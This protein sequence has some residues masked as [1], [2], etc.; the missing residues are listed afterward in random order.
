MALI[1]CP[2]CGH[3]VLSVA[4]TCPNCQHRMT[5]EVAHSGELTTV[6]QCR[7]CGELMS[8]DSTR[9]PHCG[10]STRR[11]ILVWIALAV[12]VVALIAVVWLVLRDGADSEPEAP[13]PTLTPEV[14]R[15]P[16]QS[17]TRPTPRDIVEPAPTEIATPLPRRA[18]RWA[19]DW[20]NV[21]TD[22]GL[23]Y[24][25]VQILRPGDSVEVSDRRLGWWAVHGDGRLIGYVANNLLDTVPPLPF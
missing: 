2:E 22:R 10:E 13:P 1:K 12:A 8:G 7:T 20:A 14:S 18:L 25:V 4:S 9:C 3:T 24:E 17:P 15:F 21:R 23:E 5:P 6:V 16:V 11:P 19:N